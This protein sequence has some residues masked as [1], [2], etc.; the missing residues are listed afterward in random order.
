MPQEV[1]NSNLAPGKSWGDLLLKDQI[2][3]IRLE[4]TPK[5]TLIDPNSLSEPIPR[6]QANRN[7]LLDAHRLRGFSLAAEALSPGSS[8]FRELGNVRNPQVHAPVGPHHD[9]LPH[10]RGRRDALRGLRWWS[11]QGWRRA[12][13]V[14]ICKP[15]PW[16]CS[17]ERTVPT[18]AVP[19]LVV[20]RVMVSNC[21]RSRL[22]TRSLCLRRCASWKARRGRRTSSSS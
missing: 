9:L 13:A 10:L 20:R 19:V 5:I 8:A 7:S 12:R 17:F 2:K 22:C 3:L 15:S 6:T 1:A 14:H 11:S 21:L 4:L 18:L 16:L